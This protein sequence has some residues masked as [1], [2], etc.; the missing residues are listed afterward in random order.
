[1]TSGV[2]EAYVGLTDETAPLSDVLRQQDRITDE[3]GWT[4]ALPVLQAQ[5]TGLRK[6]LREGFEN[7]EEI[8]LWT[9]AAAAISVGH[10][11]PSFGRRIVSD[12]WRVATLLK[13]ESDRE[14]MCANPPSEEIA[15]SERQSIIQADLSPR[16][17]EALST[18]RGSAADYTDDE[19][20][21]HLDKQRFIAMRPRVHQLAVAQHETLCWAL[22][23][24][25]RQAVQDRQ[26]VQKWLDYA[27]YACAGALPDRV[28]QN[29]LS[30][31][32]DWWG[33]LIADDKQHLISLLAEDMLGP[34]T[35]A[36]YVAAT[37]AEERPSKRDDSPDVDPTPT[38]AY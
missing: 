38:E 20:V 4:P 24:A 27:G 3:V 10:L 2:D 19:G 37:N 35:D 15:R 14:R 7:R 29:A 28:F 1:M 26:S 13:S 16:F 21:E 5:Q 12:R 11:E 18:M 22:D 33:A 25:E 8:L 6:S 32:S 17:Q 36:L 31:A 23:R 30:P 9:H 34:M